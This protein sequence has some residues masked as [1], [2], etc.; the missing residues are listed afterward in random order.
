MSPSAVTAS[1]RQQ[2]A[3]DLSRLAGDSDFVPWRFLDAGR[4]SASR[5]RHCGRPKPAYNRRSD[6]WQMPASPA[7]EH[8]GLATTGVS[9]LKLPWRGELT[10]PQCQLGVSEPL[11]ALC[12]G[13]GA[14]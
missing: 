11:T 6:P 1:Y 3:I 12:V 5:A 10:C 4:P 9:K 14:L 2:P 7:S 8:P 13:G